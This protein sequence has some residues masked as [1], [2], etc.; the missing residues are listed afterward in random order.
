MI[1][2]RQPGLRNIE[3]V[4]NTAFYNNGTQLLL[5]IFQTTEYRE[6]ALIVSV[7]MPCDLPYFLIKNGAK[8]MC[9]FSL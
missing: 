7:C 8:Y 5:C 1:N 4:F 2:T 3:I 6:N 9:A